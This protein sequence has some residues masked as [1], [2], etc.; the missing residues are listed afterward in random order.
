MNDKFRNLLVRTATS[1]V[2][3]VVVLGAMILGRLTFAV[4]L[5]AITSGCMW[6]LYGL[7]E[8]G[9]SAPNKIIGT[10]LGLLVV[11][12]SLG[13]VE[14]LVNDFSFLV[15]TGAAFVLS[16]ALTVALFV[17]EMWKPKG[18]SPMS[19]I[20]STLLGVAYIAL[21]MS[22]FA[23]FPLIGNKLLSWEAMVPVAF[24]LIVWAGD[25]FAY[26]VGIA[27]GRHK[28]CERLSPKKSWEGFIGGVAGAMA[29]GAVAGKF[30]VEGSLW[31]WMGLGLLVGLA[32]VLG[33]L[34]ESN[35]KRS[36]GAKDSGKILP[37]H[38]G[39][40]DRFD[41]MLVAIPLAFIF[42]VVMQVMTGHNLMQILTKLAV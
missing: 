21:P 5:L 19:N 29:V 13:L 39:L 32:A 37:G 18:G 24:I 1:V 17:L 36:A 9:G 30:L 11:G 16:I 31:L 42:F 3:V 22:L 2:F 33:D 14:S 35:F 10:L 15:V 4:L 12:V 25:T 26:L 28:L 27:F 38:G 6:E 34:V 20:G 41:A 23:L 8:K 40:L 7:A